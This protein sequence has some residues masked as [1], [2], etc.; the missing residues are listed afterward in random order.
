MRV[1]QETKLQP[2]GKKG[3]Q[4]EA[5]QSAEVMIDPALMASEQVK[6]CLVSWSGPDFEGRPAT[7]ENLMLLPP[8]IVDMI[9]AAA[10]ELNQGLSDEEKNQ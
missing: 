5:E 4:P 2:R 9:A 6:A 8:Y 7:P 1:T 10:D 3:P